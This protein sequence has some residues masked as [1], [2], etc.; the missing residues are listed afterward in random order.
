[1][2]KSGPRRENLEIRISKSE[3]STKPKS[4]MFKTTP[5]KATFSDFGHSSVGLVS[6]FEIRDSNF[7]Q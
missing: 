6:T 5:A 3:T 1:M 2:S 7:P 4:R